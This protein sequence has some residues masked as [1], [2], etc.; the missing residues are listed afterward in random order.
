MRSRWTVHP[1]VAWLLPEEGEAFDPRGRA[2]AGRCHA[3]ACRRRHHGR[4]GLLARLSL[5][6]GTVSMELAVTR[7][8]ILR[9]N[10]RGAELDRGERRACRAPGHSR[11][12]PPCRP[13]LS[14]SVEIT[15]T[16]RQG[17]S[18]CRSVCGEQA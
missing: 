14:R 2:P 18:W 6:V 1:R 4:P 11:R 8:P 13:I 10:L 5:L 9:A 12:H 15:A 7:R 17:H 16:E 3:P